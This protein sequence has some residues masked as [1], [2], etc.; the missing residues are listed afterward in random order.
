MS[1]ESMEALR[2]IV[3]EV[4]GLLGEKLRR[5]HTLSL[6]ELLDMLPRLVCREW[7]SLKPATPLV[8]KTGE[9][10]L[11]V[12]DPQAYAEFLEGE[13]GKLAERV[14]DLAMEA[15]AKHVET[16]DDDSYAKLSWLLVSY[17]T[18][19]AHRLNR[20]RRVARRAPGLAELIALLITIRAFA[21][22]RLVSSLDSSEAARLVPGIEA[23]LAGIEQEEETVLERVEKGMLPVHAS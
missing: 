21:L 13:L 23:V 17:S 10:S 19:V 6:T 8:E 16:M 7:K 18:R 9:C 2:R 20:L 14:I 5:Y 1:E 12:R 15:L 4:A 11:E 3:D 22:F